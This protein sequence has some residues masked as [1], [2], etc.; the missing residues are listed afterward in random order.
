MPKAW[1]KEKWAEFK[2]LKQVAEIF[3]VT[4][5]SMWIRLKAMGLI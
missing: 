1:V 3:Q 4:E 2:D 5:V